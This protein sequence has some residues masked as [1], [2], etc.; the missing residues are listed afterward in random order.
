MNNLY[1][2]C[3]S[4]KVFVDAGYRWAYWTLEEAGV[5]K[6][7]NIVDPGSVLAAEEYWNPEPD[8]R[9]KWLLEEVLPSVR[10]FIQEHGE[11]TIVFDES[12]VFHDTGPDWFL[13]WIQEGYLFYP[14]P[15]FCLE[16]L[17][18]NSW[19]AV[20]EYMN[21][22]RFKPSWWTDR[23]ERERAERWYK[24]RLIRSDETPLSPG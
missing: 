24:A 2:A 18:C 3:T 5:V 8:D 23:E 14:L 16:R 6:R 19:T 22:V 10:R 1:F 4:C 20:C 17:R 12:D 11:H 7:R 9:S 21:R 13:E 15:R